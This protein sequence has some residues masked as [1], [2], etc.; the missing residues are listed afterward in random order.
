MKLLDLFFPKRCPYCMELI[1][2]EQLECDKCRSEFPRKPYKRILP[3]GNE[4]VSA[5]IYD[6]K[7][8]DALTRYKFGGKR[9]FYKSFGSALA[10]TVAESELIA[11]IV[12]SV[13][14]SKKRMH[15]RGY[16]QAE[17][18]ARETARLLGLDYSETLIKCRENL[19]QHTLDNKLRAEN[20]IGVYQLADKIEVQDKT[21]LLIDDIVTTGHTLSECCR[22]LSQ[23]G[24]VKIICGTVAT[25]C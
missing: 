15:T 7:V 21:I 20:I 11:D 13:P 3:S 18:I 23:Y 12:T 25:V 14:L 10:N 22:V 1:Y 16:N 6:S 5:F 17:L 8:R 24:N 9:E 4:C 2:R 19:E